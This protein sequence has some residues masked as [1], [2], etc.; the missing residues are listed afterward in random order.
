MVKDNEPSE[1]TDWLQMRIH[2]LKLFKWALEENLFSGSYRAYVVEIQTEALIIRLAE[3][4]QKF[5][6]QP[7]RVLAVKVRH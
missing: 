7:Q 1:K 4:Q 6:F 2:S 3:L 5:K